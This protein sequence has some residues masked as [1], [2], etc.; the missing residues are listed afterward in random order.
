[1]RHMVKSSK[2]WI[3]LSPE[4]QGCLHL[5]GWRGSSPCLSCL[6]NILYW[7]QAIPQISSSLSLFREVAL[8]A[9]SEDHS[10]WQLTLF[11]AFVHMLVWVSFCCVPKDPKTQW[12]W[13]D[14]VSIYL[15]YDPVVQRVWL[16]ST[17]QFFCWSLL[18]SCRQLVQVH[19]G[20]GWSTGASARTCRALIPQQAKTCSHDG[21]FQELWEK[22]SFST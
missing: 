20:A 16:S 3:L 22:T 5:S 10:A 7:E 17:G 11:E 9:F 14:T 4:I 2:F 15:A 1:M 21:E 19:L 8:L 13:C 12:F 6:R 18:G